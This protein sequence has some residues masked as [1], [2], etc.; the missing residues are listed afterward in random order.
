VF[1][2]LAE[3]K[4]WLFSGLGLTVLSSLVGLLKFGVSRWKERRSSSTPSA[5]DQG[6]TPVHYERVMRK[7]V[8]DKL[9][10]FILRA[11]VRPEEVAS[12][13]NIDLRGDTPIGL[14]LNA[15]VPHIEMY[16]EITN[17]SQFDLVLDR[18]LVEVWFGQPTF[19]SAVL[20]RYLVPGGE[21]TR[22]IF[23][24]HAL[25]AEQRG[26]IVEFE[27]ADQSRGSIHIY[28]TAYLESS[29]GR[30]EVARNIERR[31]P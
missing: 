5:I 23:F 13:V 24:R 25:S 18:L 16:F 31:K 14:G 7:T 12:K 15:A 8:V 27:K 21:I 22:N 4:E 1:R 9:P 28:L 6:Q 29:L 26:Q 30:I 20:K 17:L 2:W 11:F 3:N 10:A 19:T